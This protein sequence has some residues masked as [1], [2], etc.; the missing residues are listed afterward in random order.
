MKVRNAGMALLIGAL[1]GTSCWAGI[2][3]A[4]KTPAKSSPAKKTAQNQDVIGSA[5][6]QA[7]RDPGHSI[8]NIQKMRIE[9][10]EAN[11]P[12]GNGSNEVRPPAPPHFDPEL[13]GAN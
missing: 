11:R 5:Q 8:E 12:A 9:L 7:I 6:G 1:A 13:D 3:P 2:S 4:T 10:N